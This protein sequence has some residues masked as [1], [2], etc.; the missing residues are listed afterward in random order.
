MRD[1]F[2]VVEIPGFLFV[3]FDGELTGPR[4]EHEKQRF[5]VRAVGE[6][7]GETFVFDAA[8][9]FGVV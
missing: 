8:G 1:V 4:A 2:R 7:G 6:R 3:D 9:S 5:F